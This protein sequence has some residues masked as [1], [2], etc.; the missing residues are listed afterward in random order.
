MKYKILNFIF[1]ILTVAC[2]FGFMRI[3]NSYSQQRFILTDLNQSSWSE[4]SEEF[5]ENIEVDF[6]NLSLTALNLKAAKAQYYLYK[7]DF[8]KGLALL[9]E[10]IKENSNPYIMFN[11]ATYAKIYNAVC[12]PDFFAYNGNLELQYRGR[13]KQLKDL[14]PIKSGERE[15]LRT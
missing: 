12:T 14:K 7:N 9:D 11:E 4:R 3:Y 2:L 1:L 5:V 13:I 15:L 6:P 10:S 8:K